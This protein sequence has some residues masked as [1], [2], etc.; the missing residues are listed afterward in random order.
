MCIS[1]RNNARAF[2]LLVSA[3]L[4]ASTVTGCAVGPDFVAPKAPTAA[5]YTSGVEPTATTIVGGASQQ[6]STTGELPADWWQLFDCT[7]LNEAIKLGLTGSPTITLAE[8]NLRE[9]QDNLRAGQGVFYPQV[10]GAANAARERPSSN[11][12]PGEGGIYNLFTLSATVDYTLDV[13]GG[14]RRAVEASGAQVDYQQNAA[15]AASLTLASNIANTI[16][17]AAAYDAEIQATNQIVAYQKEQVRLA[18][19]QVKSGMGT[20]A[21]ELSLQTQ[22]ETTEAQIPALRQ[23]LTQ[24]Q[25]LLAVLGGKLPA[26]VQPPQIQFADLTLPRALPV[27]LPSALVRQRPDI[28]QAQASLHAASAEI[29]VATAAMLPSI[30]LDGALGTSSTSISNLMIPSSKLWSVGA[31]LTQPVFHGGSLWFQRKAA[32]DAYDAAVASYQQTVLSAF[33]QV[34]DTLRAL[35]HDADALAIDEKALATAKRALDLTQANYQAGL[36]VY[37]DVLIANAQYQQLQIVD[38]QARAA[39]YQDTVAL[40]A[41]LGGGWWNGNSNVETRR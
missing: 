40:F 26:E 36:A 9:A 6:L 37:S 1:A 18:A 7:K 27:S 19:V 29:G 17:A 39:R 20:V 41:A 2:R 38:I 22:L 16:I 35:Q 28:L 21:A 8:A 31:G 12:V 32:L 14:E 34:A 24:A 10:N 5:Q 23:K 30:T 11:A 3:A 33:E 15:R 4:S 13:F 25:D